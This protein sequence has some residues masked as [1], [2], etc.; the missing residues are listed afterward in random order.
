MSRV[1]PLPF[2][3]PDDIVERASRIELVIL[4]VDGVLTDGSVTYGP[5]GAEYKTFHIRDGQGIKSLMEAGIDT[6][7]ISARSAAALDLRARE[8]D[9]GHVETGAP[10]KRPVF[11]AL[12]QRCS[13]SAEQCCYVGDDLMDIPVMLECGLAVAVADAHHTV[14]HIAAWVTPSPGG[15]GAAREVSDLVLYA[16]Q[17]FDAIMDRHLTRSSTP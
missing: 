14:R 2:A 11:D 5:E 17:D 1:W 7:V 16:R 12:R 10:D 4:D 13:L 8:L 9:I 6:A 15:R 3:A